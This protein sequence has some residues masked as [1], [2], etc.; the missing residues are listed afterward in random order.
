MNV[1]T[2]RASRARQIAV[3]FETH[4]E[5]PVRVRLHRPDIERRPERIA[6]RRCPAECQQREAHID[7][8]LRQ[9]RNEVQRCMELLDSPLVVPSPEQTHA[10]FERGS[11]A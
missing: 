2:H 4:G 1:C 10:P 6:R 3:F 5:S 11:Q 8:S 7:V 9:C